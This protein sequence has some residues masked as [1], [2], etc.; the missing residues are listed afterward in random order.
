MMELL[1]I[2][3]SNQLS[4]LHRSWVEEALRIRGRIRQKRW[5]KSTAV[6]GLLFVERVKIELGARGFGRSIISSAEGHEPREPQVY[7]DGHSGG[8]KRP[9]SHEN[10]LPWRT[11]DVDAI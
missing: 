2:R 3:D 9:L 7:Y 1:G 10:N 4:L 5:S 11:Y 6:G 8:K